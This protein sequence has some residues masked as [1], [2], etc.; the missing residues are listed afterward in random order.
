MPQKSFGVYKYF[1][2]YGRHFFT[3]N[4]GVSARL[5]RDILT[6]SFRRSSTSLIYRD[7]CLSYE[8]VYLRNNTALDAIDGKVRTSWLFR[9]NLATL[10]S[11][12][13]GIRDV[14]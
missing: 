10:G 5:D 13:Q 2:L 8:L 7:D 4:W 1:Q 6:N 12:R 3:E 11:S 9:L 14:R